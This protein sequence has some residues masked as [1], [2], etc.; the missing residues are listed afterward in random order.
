VIMS[1]RIAPWFSRAVLL[2]ALAVLALISRKFVGDPVGAAT[3]SGITLN[4]PLGITNMRASFGAFPL[5]CALFVLVCLVTSSLRR[6]GLVFV[7]FIVG[8]AL[9]VR[10]LGI[11]LDGTLAESLRVVGAE[12]VL[13]ILSLAAYSGERLMNNNP[14]NPR[15]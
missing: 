6:T 12:T 8:T 5:G 3:A 15:S 2:A 10:L 14:V 11:I 7:M 9:A 13:L 4:T 1:A